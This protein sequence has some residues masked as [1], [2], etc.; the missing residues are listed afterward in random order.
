MLLVFLSPSVE[1]LFLQLKNGFSV[2]P[3]CRG[4][5]FIGSFLALQNSVIPTFDALDV[6]EDAATQIES[7]VITFLQWLSSRYYLFD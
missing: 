2:E 7:R 5:S 1:F 3:C 4:C 6:L